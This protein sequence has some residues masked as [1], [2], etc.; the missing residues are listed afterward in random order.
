MELPEIAPAHLHLDADGRIDQNSTCVRCGYNLRGLRP[1]SACP[2]C[3]TAVGRSLQGDLLRFAPPDWVETLA[4]GMSWIVAGILVGFVSGLLVA[5]A[6]AASWQPLVVQAVGIVG[7]IGYWKVA[8]PDPGIS[9]AEPPVNARKLVRFTAVLNYVL[10]LSQMGAMQVDARLGMALG[11]I[12]AICG[13]VGYFAIFLY[14]RRLALRIP[15]QRLAKHTIIVMWG[16][17]VLAVFGLLMML[18]AAAVAPPSGASLATIG[19]FTGLGM[20]VF[21][22]W[23]LVL[24]LWFRR[25]LSQAAREART[26]WARPIHQPPMPGSGY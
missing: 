19:C 14:A 11:V 25:E 23:S 7:V 6:A 22:I 26:T 4:S 17:I 5:V 16:I 2:E 9:E 12:V 8:T 10:G 21:A 24:I 13:I 15:N 18:G 1:E 20:L 3:G